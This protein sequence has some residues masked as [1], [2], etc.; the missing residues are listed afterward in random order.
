MPTK[1]MSAKQKF[2][3]KERLRYSRH[4]LLKEMGGDGQYRLK[5][6]R[7]LMIGA[8]G[9]GAPC[10]LY[11]AAAGIGT[12]GIID[13]DVIALDNLQRQIIYQTKDIAQPKSQT[14]QSY[15][16][17]LNPEITIIAHPLRLTKDNIADI[18]ADYDFI[19]DGSDNF[20]TRF[21]VNDMSHFMKK[22][23]ITAAVGQFDGQV[24]SFRSFETDERTGNP[25]PSWRCLVD[26]QPPQDELCAQGIL[27]ALCG[28]VG[29]MQALEIIKQITHIGENLLSKIWIYDGLNGKS[30]IIDLRWNPH[31]PLNGK[32]A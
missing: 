32:S 20:A 4:I 24:A 22:T 18:F 10:L 14:A 2:S 13:D 30:R 9:L 19:A 28:V 6:A 27:G 26:C 7:V 3:A 8:G 12:I 23:L 29:S 31:N 25:R 1:Q 11:L 16:R 17:A 21:L 5:Q 15:L